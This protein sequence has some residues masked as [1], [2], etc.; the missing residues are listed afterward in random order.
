[1]TPEREMSEGNENICSICWEEI[2]DPSVQLACKHKFHYDCLAE[3]SKRNHQCP[4]CRQDFT[5]QR[6]PAPA[7]SDGAATAIWLIDEHEVGVEHVL[8]M[9]LSSIT[10]LRFLAI[11]FPN[12]VERLFEP[13][14][15]LGR[16][17]QDVWT[18]YPLVAPSI[19]AALII[20]A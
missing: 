6:G 20:F 17:L 9:M 19:V 5:T 14:I 12:F 2:R 11:L 3:W 1:M 4:L 8:T 10:A 13:Q 15:K 18:R 7:A 16:T